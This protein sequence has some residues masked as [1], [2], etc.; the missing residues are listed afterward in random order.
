[1]LLWRARE[2]GKATNL[3]I[4][5]YD[6]NILDPRLQ[7]CKD[8]FSVTIWEDTPPEDRPREWWF[9]EE[10]TRQR[11]SAAAGGNTSGTK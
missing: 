4:L 3:T 2:D 5:T 8:V 9:H 7:H 10:S 1:M 6:P 11:L